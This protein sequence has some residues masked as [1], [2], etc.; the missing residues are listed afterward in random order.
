[1]PT[2]VINFNLLILYNNFVPSGPRAC[3]VLAIS[4]PGETDRAASGMNGRSQSCR[5]NC[6]SSLSLPHP[7][8][9][10]LSPSW[11][12][13]PHSSPARLDWPCPSVPVIL[14]FPDSASCTRLLSRFPRGTPTDPNAGH[15]DSGHTVL[16]P[17]ID[18]QSYLLPMIL[19]R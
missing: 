16:C 11:H 5:Y 2:A 18:Q 19:W 4:S 9:M 10:A 3:K 8:H 15:Q 7:S 6:C 14:C 17:T 13:R 1:M 12:L